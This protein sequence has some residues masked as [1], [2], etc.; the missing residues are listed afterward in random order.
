MT[1]MRRVIYISLAVVLIVVG[2]I[3]LPLPIPLGVI[4]IVCGL[5]LLVSVSATAA[6]Y[7]RNYRQNHPTTDKYVRAAEERLPEAWKKVLKK[8]D[9]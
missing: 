2:L 1:G 9:P 3:V 5:I 4:M 8:T 6:W 7:V